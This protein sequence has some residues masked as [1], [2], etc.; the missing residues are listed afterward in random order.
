[1]TTTH[2]LGFPRIGRQRELKFALE[3]YWK[4]AITEEALLEVAA[5]LRIQNW[6]DQA[7]LDWLPAG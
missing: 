4:N 1:M 5:N 7:A 2:S 6:Q 3:R